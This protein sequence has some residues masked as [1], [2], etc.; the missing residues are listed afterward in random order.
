MVLVI[1]M[2]VGRGHK[3]YA[4]VSPKYTN[5][6]C[7]HVHADWAYECGTR[8]TSYQGPIGAGDQRDESIHAK[9]FCNQVQ[10]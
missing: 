7:Y 5:L 8:C 3:S 2:D 4:H 6:L 1:N 10:N 9:F